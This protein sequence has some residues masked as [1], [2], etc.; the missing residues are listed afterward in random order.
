MNKCKQILQQAGRPLHILPLR[1]YF[2]AI[3]ANPTFNLYEKITTRVL[4]WL[5][6]KLLNRRMTNLVH[7][8][9]VFVFT[10]QHIL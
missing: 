10:T 5:R 2:I 3:N 8:N 7:F 6:Q 4:S 1:E 9:V